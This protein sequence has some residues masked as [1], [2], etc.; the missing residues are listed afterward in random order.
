MV[1]PQKRREPGG[2]SVERKTGLR[3]SLITAVLG[4]DYATPRLKKK[5]LNKGPAPANAPRRS[6]APV[7]G[8]DEVI[9]EVRRLREQE[10]LNP[11]AIAKRM[12]ELG[13]PMDLHRARGIC[14]YTTR[15]HLI[16]ADNASPYIT[17][18]AAP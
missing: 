6:S 12:T 5:N 9:L 10:G 7:K 16:P 1:A 8:S 18:K 14:E 15:A 13:H 17:T 4:A 11:S 2:M 3:D